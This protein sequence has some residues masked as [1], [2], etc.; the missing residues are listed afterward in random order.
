MA[1]LLIFVVLLPVLLQPLWLHIWPALLAYEELRFSFIAL[2]EVLVFILLIQSKSLQVYGSRSVYT[3]V[4]AK[5][6]LLAIL[7]L[8]VSLLWS[9]NFWV[10]L[11]FFTYY[12]A[13]ALFFIALVFICQQVELRRL[14]SF[15]YLPLASWLLLI[16]FFIAPEVIHDKYFT[17]LSDLPGFRHTR[18][19]AQYALF[20]LFI[21]SFLL[22][23]TL[24]A[25]VFVGT[26]LFSVQFVLIYLLLLSG[27]R[28]CVIL[29]VLFLL[30]TVIYHRQKAYAGLNLILF[31]MAFL[32]AWLWPFESYGLGVC[33]LWSCDLVVDGNKAVSIGA[34]TTGRT[35]LWQLA[36]EQIKASQYMGLGIGS[37]LWAA[38]R[39]NDLMYHPHNFVL[40]FLQDLGVIFIVI[41]A[42]FNVALVKRVIDFGYHRLPDIVVFSGLGLCFFY[43]LALVDGIFYFP[44]PILMVLFFAALIFRYTFFDKL[45]DMKRPPISFLTIKKSAL[46]CI[47]LMVLLINS[48]FILWHELYQK[49]YKRYQTFWPF[50]QV[51]PLNLESV[52]PWLQQRSEQL[53]LAEWVAE[54]SRLQASSSHPA[55]FAFYQ[56]CTLAFRDEVLLSKWMEADKWKALSVVDWD[57]IK[58]AYQY[59]PKFKQKVQVESACYTSTYSG[60]YLQGLNF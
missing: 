55:K 14:L 45:C 31:I 26:L 20:L 53:A 30:L 8:A 4:F 22:A 36:L 56:F 2:I 50:I 47:V 44:E 35:A 17:W 24:R 15:L 33:R 3:L 60:Y 16:L 27:S 58:H 39:F 19:A 41:F 10:S 7:L 42:M 57:N 43:M 51:V 49:D 13:H 21:N 25:K 18:A 40:Q 54:L 38:P 32:L 46:I 5:P 29:M 12:C 52:E 9:G 1:Y 28:A 59:L 48:V 34:V 11:R 6:L 37:T 23:S